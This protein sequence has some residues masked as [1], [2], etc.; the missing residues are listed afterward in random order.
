MRKK[1]IKNRIRRILKMINLKLR[2]Q[3]KIQKCL[4]RKMEKIKKILNKLKI[5]KG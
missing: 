5:K 4:I 1:E 2:M 3:K